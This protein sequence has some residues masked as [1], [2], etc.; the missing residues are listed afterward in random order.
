M[1]WKHN[2]PSGRICL[3]AGARLH[4]DHNLSHEI[5]APQPFECLRRIFPCK[6]F[7]D[8]G[9]DVVFLRPI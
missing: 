7:L 2:L 9:V 3:F 6:R 1:T 5:L 4:F 8:L